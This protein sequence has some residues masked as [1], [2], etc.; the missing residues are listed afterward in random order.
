MTF[1]KWRTSSAVENDGF[2]ILSASFRMKPESHCRASCFANCR[3]SSKTLSP[4]SGSTPPSEPW[5]GRGREANRSRL[6]KQHRS[7]AF[8]LSG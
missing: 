2:S 7:K 6:N 5:D 4:S 1:S 8:Y 3:V